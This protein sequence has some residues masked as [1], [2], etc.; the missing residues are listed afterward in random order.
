MHLTHADA[1]D[2]V[3]TV[4]WLAGAPEDFRQALLARSSVKHVYHDEPIY[5]I[6]E[7]T[8]GIYGVASGGVRIEV[9][10]NERGPSVIHFA[11]AGFWGGFGPVVANTARLAGIKASGQATVLHISQHDYAALAAADP[12][13]WRWAA[14]C[15]LWS[16]SISLGVI[17]DMMIRSSRRRTIALLLRLAGYRCAEPGFKASS[18]ALT[19]D[20]LGQIANL[21]RS[22]LST[23]LRDLEGEGFITCSYRGIAI[24]DA[25]ALL[26]RLGE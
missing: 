16:L 5:R 12:F 13:A 24:R 4:G 1:I 20:E 2:V 8:G 3:S 25:A 7:P 10:T 21:S 15:L 6:E 11:G 18:V 17:D 14:Q 9:A 26:A 23:I 19:Q 22:H